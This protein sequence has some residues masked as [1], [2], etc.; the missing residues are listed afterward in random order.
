MWILEAVIELKA[1]A[2]VSN[3]HDTGPSTEPKPP[4][5]LAEVLPPTISELGWFSAVS[6]LGL[7]D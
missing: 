7:L 5:G 1:R 3:L 2:K 4:A 6:R